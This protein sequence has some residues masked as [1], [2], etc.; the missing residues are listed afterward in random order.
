V[1]SSQTLN[2]S[3]KKSQVN[4]S[5]TLNPGHNNGQA[6]L[7]HS[8]TPSLSQKVEHEIQ[9][10]IGET[11]ENQTGKPLNEQQQQQISE[12][13]KPENI[14]KVRRGFFGRV[15]SGTWNLTK[16]TGRMIKN[17]VGPATIGATTSGALAFAEVKKGLKS[18]AAAAGLAALGSIKNRAAKKATNALPP[19]WGAATEAIM[20]NRAKNAPPEQKK[21]I[22]K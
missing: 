1:N 4:S 7:V 8:Q 13:T 19:T 12:L 22:P 14:Q 16:K 3:H 5:Q 20:K 2:L 17:Q 18:K 21:I 10:E 9:K 15:G 11:I 6:I